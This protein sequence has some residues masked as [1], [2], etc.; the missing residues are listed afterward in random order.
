MTATALQS[1]APDPAPQPRVPPALAMTGIRHAYGDVQAVDGVDVAVAPGEVV[2]LLGPSGCGKTTILRLA[3]GL[4]DLQE[5][6]VSLDGRT[7]AGDGANLAPEK[8]GVGL[9]FQDYALFPHL[10]VMGNVT[11]GLT[12]WPAGDRIA[13]GVEVLEMVGLAD[14]ASAYPHELSGG[15]QQRVAL[16]RALAPKPRVVLLDEPYS[17]L[18]ARLRDRVRD[19]VL[20]ILK[21]SGSACLMV[22]HD[23][24]EAMFM[25]DRIAVMRNGRIVQQGSPADLYCA[26]ADAF[27]AAF[28][29]DVN[30]ID[31]QVRD[32]EV[33]TLV[34]RLPAP[35]LADGQP[36]SV[37]IRPEGVRIETLTDSFTREPH[38]EVEQARLLGRTS[39]I[40]MTLRGEGPR[41]GEALHLH[42]RVPGVFLPRPGARVVISVDPAQTFVFPARDTN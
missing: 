38:G 5:G 34:G 27:V 42:A 25:A 20:H 14:M 13:R 3:A 32:G 39:L 11:F 7:V 30:L 15:Q 4:E 19:E 21:S 10:D 33:D 28:F 9:V 22:T 8:R 17:G 24:E 1:S 16:A 40:H 2:C 37:V 23:S 26:P 6:R 18:D 35:G 36:V 31:G 12:G 29:G 41:I